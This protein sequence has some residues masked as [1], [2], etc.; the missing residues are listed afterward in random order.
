VAGDLMFKILYTQII[1]R[2]KRVN[3]R[4]LASKSATSYGSFHL[5]F[6]D[7]GDWE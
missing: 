4:G 7:D 5:Y 1:L 2:N 6:T 3:F